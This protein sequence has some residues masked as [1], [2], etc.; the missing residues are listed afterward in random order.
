VKHTI[1]QQR[2]VRRAAAAL[3]WALAT[4]TVASVGTAGAA[5]AVTTSTSGTVAASAAVQAAAA[6]PPSF[7]F[8]GSG[9]GHG[10]GMSQYGAY[11]M[12]LDGKSSTE[13]LEHYFAPAKV[14]RRTGEPSIRVLVLGE[15][16]YDGKVTSVTVSRDAAT[17]WTL[18]T[19]PSTTVR[20]A[21]TSITF[22]YSTAS[23]TARV[24]AVIDGKEYRTNP[25]TWR[26]LRL[27]WSGGTVSVPR[28]N[29]GTG[30]VR[31]AH[32]SLA[33]GPNGGGMAVVNTLKLNTEYMYGIAEMPSSWPSAALQAQ[34]TAA[35]TYAYRKLDAA[36][37]SSLWDL[38]DEPTSQKFTGWN[39]ENEATYGV[40][41]V[42]AV[43][44]TRNDAGSTVVRAPDGTLAETYYSSS[45]GG[46]TTTSEEVWGSATLPYLRSQ[47][48]HWSS[49]PRVKNPYASWTT[50]LTQAQVKAKFPTLADVARL[51]VT[52]RA[53]SGAAMQIRATSSTGASALLL[54]KPTTDGVRTKMGLR[55]AY[56]H[57]GSVSAVQRIAGDDR[58]A[59]AAAIARQAFPTGQEV[60]IVSGQQ[61]SIVDGLV[62]SPFARSIGAPVLLSR[63]EELPD[64]T[65]AEITRRGA[66]HATIIGSEGV[67]GRGVVTALEDLG[68][69]VSRLWGDDRYGTANAVARA[70]DEA[71]TVVIASGLVTDLVDAAAAAGPAAASGQPVLLVPRTSISS[72]TRATIK[73]LGATKAV[74][75]GSEAVVSRAVAD[76]LRADGLTVTRLGGPTR[77]ETATAVADA[78]EPT[79]GTGTVVLASGLDAN[80]V[81]A[82][83]GGVLGH[84]TLLTAGPSIPAATKAWFAQRQVPALQVLGS[85]GVIPN[86]AVEAVR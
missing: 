27:T 56:V 85:V 59:T 17:T 21:A 20:V 78:Y 72:A 63:T 55:S 67:V 71:S 80:L 76:A 33:F 11:G 9:W 10:L 19:A 53:S 82:L 32:G 38:T 34:V 28:A 50:T 47:D 39:K 79:V 66:T 41:W 61:L 23:G 62:A 60:V 36:G 25:T 30:S 84:V 12:A 1:V 68:L 8:T 43:D 73:A 5:V 54:T 13:I 75:V 2:G 18:G 16:L 37:A 74:L 35:R 69:S 48:D 70:E 65:V 31:Y 7:T 81:D 40:R 46:Q 64:V 52:Q 83:A 58:F 3:A 29:G 77:F 24:S 49:D 22:V 57:V 42:A 14:V 86:S 6:V 4:L 44:A 51:T 45:T 15:S 26:D